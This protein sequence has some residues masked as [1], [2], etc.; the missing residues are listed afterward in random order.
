[1]FRLS[2]LWVVAVLVVLFGLFVLSSDVDWKR[3]GDIDGTRRDGRDRFGAWKAMSASASWSVRPAWSTITTQGSVGPESA[4]PTTSRKDF[5]QQTDAR[6]DNSG[7]GVVVRCTK[8]ERFGVGAGTGNGQ[9]LRPGGAGRLG[10]SPEDSLRRSLPHPGPQAVIQDYLRAE[11]CVL[12]LIGETEKEIKSTVSELWAARGVR[13]HAL[14]AINV[15]SVRLSAQRKRIDRRHVEIVR[16]YRAL[17]KLVDGWQSVPLM[18]HR[19]CRVPGDGRVEM[20]LL[21]AHRMKELQA[22]RGVLAG[23]EKHQ[24]AAQAIMRQAITKESQLDA[25]RDHLQARLALLNQAFQD[26]LRRKKRRHRSREVWDPTARRLARA[27]ADLQEKVRDQ[28]RSFETI[29]GLLARPVPGIVIRPRLDRRL[30]RT[31]GRGRS[32]GVLIGAERGWKARAPAMGTVRFAGAVPGFGRVVMIDHGE[33]FL[34]VVGYLARLKVR[35]GQRIRQGTV[36]GDVRGRPGRDRKEPLTC[37]YELRRGSVPLD[38]VQWFHGG[39]HRGIE[40]IRPKVPGSI[41]Q[42]VFSVASASH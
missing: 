33:G 8:T 11:L 23:L 16:W 29:K 17:Y 22:E 19:R 39:R 25:V 4:A 40:T 41:P 27:V 42:D 24:N 5:A 30:A 13:H 32:H 36:L 28:G 31:G 6:G 37:Y 2:S 7:E 1:M 10:R 26:L 38:P 9:T 18:D 3:F 14:E 35:V 15:G 34:S 21:I 12:G 20:A